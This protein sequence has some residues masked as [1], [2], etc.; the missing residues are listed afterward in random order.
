MERQ[1]EQAEPWRALCQ[2]AVV[3][4]DV[5][6]LIQLSKEI[7]RLLTERENRQKLPASNAAF[8]LARTPLHEGQR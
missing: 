3:E 5:D 1:I 6:K 2:Q 4:K 8:S 7:D